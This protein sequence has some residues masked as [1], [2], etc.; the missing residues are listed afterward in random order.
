[1]PA[2]AIIRRESRI[3]GPSLGIAH[4][5]CPAAEQPVADHMRQHMTVA[6]R[7][8]IGGRR[9]LHPVAGADPVRL[10][11]GLFD[12]VRAEDRQ[13]RRLQRGL[14]MLAASGAL[15]LE[16]RGEGAERR[17]HG[18][19][20]IDIGCR[21]LG[22]RAGCAGDV[23]RAGERLADPVESALRGAR[24]LVAERALGDQDDLRAQRREARPIEAERGE[25][26]RRQVGD[27]DVR[28]AQQSLHDLATCGTAGVERQ[29]ALVAGGLEEHTAFTA[30]ADRCD[31]AVFAAADLLDADDLRAEV[32]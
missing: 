31:V 32:A 16:E 25:P 22:R 9:G 20:V 29:R 10:G 28:G 23:H 4:Q 24:A 18:R 7:E 14:Y 12:E 19:R 3:A 6:R 1:M 5:A 2:A 8:H 27:H 13:R 21:R 17:E 26:A 15:P 11:D 30:L